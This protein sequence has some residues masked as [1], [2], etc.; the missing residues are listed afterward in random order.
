MG[1]HI[2]S[3]NTRQMSRMIVFRML[4]GAYHFLFSLG[5]GRHFPTLAGK[6]MTHTSKKELKLPA[7][8]INCFDFQSHPSKK[9][10]VI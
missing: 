4:T 7:I 6:K 5:I 9:D 1:N 3:L 10:D 2:D 8:C